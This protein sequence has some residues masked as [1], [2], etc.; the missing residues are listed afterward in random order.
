MEI[1]QLFKISFIKTIIFNVHYF[2]LKS[3]FKP[4][5]ILSKNVKLSKLK[6]RL[7]FNEFDRICNIG[8]A[9]NMSNSGKRCKTI[10]YNEGTII[11]NGHFCISKGDVICCYKDG[12]I[13]IGK[14]FHISQMSSIICYKH[15]KFGNNNTISWNVLFMDSDT[16][17]LLVNDRIINEDSDIIIGDEVW[18]CCNTFITKGSVIPSGGVIAS[19]SKVTSKLSIE[20]ALYI[21]NNDVKHNVKYK[22]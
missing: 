2:G 14:N 16:H 21:N 13:E 15:I 1:R 9:E 19:N 4:K 8:F 22:I 7:S 17:K 20:N 10:F 3:F 5:I 11:F 12:L 18:I 6:G